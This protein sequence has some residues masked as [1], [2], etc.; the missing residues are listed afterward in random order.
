MFFEDL[1]DITEEELEQIGYNIEPEFKIEEIQKPGKRLTKID[2][3]YF[4]EYKTKCL[5][6]GNRE[7]T[8]KTIS[9]FL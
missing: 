8:R 6:F 7:F 3:K 2:K 4:V 5:T 1:E 9:G